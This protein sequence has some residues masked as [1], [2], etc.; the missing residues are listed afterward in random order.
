MPPT[1]GTTPII[2]SNDYVAH[3]IYR[4]TT[5]FLTGAVL[6]ARESLGNLIMD[7]MVSLTD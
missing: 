2:V 1:H 3:E 7:G 4:I 6:A 5:A